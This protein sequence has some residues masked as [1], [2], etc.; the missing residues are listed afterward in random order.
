[1]IKNSQQSVNRENIGQH[2]KGHI[3]QAPCQHYTQ[4]KKVKVYFSRLETR[5]KCLL[6][7]LLFN[8]VLEV[9]SNKKK[10]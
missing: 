2:N 7:P 1:M 10:K 6:L 4:E 5:Q 8:I 3:W 9:Q